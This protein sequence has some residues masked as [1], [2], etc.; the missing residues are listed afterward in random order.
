MRDY[1]V[2]LVAGIA[3][4]GSI[5]IGIATATAQDEPTGNFRPDARVDVSRVT[6]DPSY[7]Q[8][9]EDSPLW[10]CRTMGNHRCG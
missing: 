3:V 10:D 6:L 9:E 5:A 2:G 7:G 8:V 1:L 4:F